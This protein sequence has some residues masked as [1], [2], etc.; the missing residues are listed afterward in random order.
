MEHMRNN[1]N[2]QRIVIIAIVSIVILV[3]GFYFY[4]FNGSISQDSDSWS[5]FGNYINGVLMPVLTAINIYVF[6]KLTTEVSKLEERRSEN[7]ISKENERIER[8]IQHEREILLLQLRKQELD[9][10]IKQMNRIFDNSSDSISIE[11]LQQVA[12]Y[13][14]SF[15]ETGLKW[16]NL[17]NYEI[18]KN[19]INSMWVKLNRYIYNIQNNKA[20]DEELFNKIYDTKAKL[21]NILM[22]A[23]LK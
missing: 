21:T 12:D 9:V 16:F 11:S 5:N 20:F 2:L 6:I 23:T 7:A 19:E 18:T 4:H 13:L 15:G 17:E 3:V 10:F 8:E 22:E 14:K 1:K